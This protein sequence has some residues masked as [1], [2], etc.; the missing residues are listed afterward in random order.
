MK[1][2]AAFKM[3]K[4]QIL[5]TDFFIAMFIFAVLL[6]F[7][8]SLWNNHNQR[9]IQQHEYNDMMIKAMRITDLL[10][11]GPGWESGATTKWE[12]FPAN[13]EVLGLATEDRVLSSAKVITFVNQVNNFGLYN[14]FREK[15]RILPYKFWFSLKDA[16]T[17][18]VITDTINLEF[19]DAGSLPGSLEDSLITLRRYAV[20]KKS[21]GT[22]Q[23]AYMEFKIWK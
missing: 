22:T 9:R 7:L 19:T 17:G 21:D 2:I 6:I 16:S 10:V 8:G 14:F 12:L 18:S 15:L 4:S 11:K 13:V 5:T 20:Y 1:S 3:K 23:N